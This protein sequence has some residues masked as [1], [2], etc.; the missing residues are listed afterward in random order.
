[1]SDAMPIIAHYQGAGIHD[2]QPESRVRETVIPAIDYVLGLEEVEALYSYLLDI[3]NPPE[4]RSLA[5]R[6]LVEPAEEMMA[7]RRKAAV[8]VEAVRASAA[9]LDSLRWADDRYYAPVIHMWGPGD[10]APAKR[11]AEF[12]EALRAAKA[13]R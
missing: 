3:T 12:A 9:G 8:S 1:M 4:A 10:P 2:F 5:A 7:N 6:R 11:P 13:A